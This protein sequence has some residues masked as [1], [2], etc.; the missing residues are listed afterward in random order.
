MRSCLLFCS[1]QGRAHSHRLKLLIGLFSMCHYYDIV[2][3]QPRF[4]L[5]FYDRSTNSRKKYFLN[6]RVF[7]WRSILISLAASQC[8]LSLAHRFW[9]VCTVVLRA[10]RLNINWQALSKKSYLPAHYLEG[11]AVC[12]LHP[13]SQGPII[14]A[15]YTGK[16]LFAL[17]CT[18]CG[19]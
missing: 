2:T 10:C 1:Y 4:S 12:C 18:L 5:V 6:C 19:I 8:L 3:D 7:C 15:F 16:T 14:F 9:I 11:F 13:H 17:F